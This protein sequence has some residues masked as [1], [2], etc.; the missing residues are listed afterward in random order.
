MKSSKEHQQAKSLNL[1]LVRPHLTE[2]WG[3]GWVGQTPVPFRAAV[4]EILERHRGPVLATRGD[5]STVEMCLTKDYYIF[6][7]SCIIYFLCLKNSLVC[8][9][10]KKVIKIAD[11]G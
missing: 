9:K 1:E 5:R 8:H 10:E 11:F 3:F 6:S 7:T 2:L 4:P